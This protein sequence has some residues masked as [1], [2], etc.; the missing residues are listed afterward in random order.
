[1]PVFIDSAADKE[2]IAGGKSILAAVASKQKQQYVPQAGVHGA[3]TLRED[4][5]PRGYAE[6]RH[7]LMK[8]FDSLAP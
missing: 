4:R 7:A 2:E 6:N 5:D 1:M 3:S 8:F